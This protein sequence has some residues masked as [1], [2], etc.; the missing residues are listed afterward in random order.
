V[1]SEFFIT[2]DGTVVCPGYPIPGEAV[3]DFRKAIHSVV[4]DVPHKQSQWFHTSLGRILNPVDS[5]KW[6]HALLMLEKQWNKHIATCLI[7]ALLWTH[8]ERWYMVEKK[9]LHELPLQ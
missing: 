5:E 2:P 8:E 3:E 7:D 4:T 1:R 9:I 6:N